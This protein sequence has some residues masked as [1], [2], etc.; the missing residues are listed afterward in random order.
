MKQAYLVYPGL[1]KT[2]LAKNNANIADI[3]TKIF[4]DASLAP[5][6]GTKDYPNYRGVVVLEINPDWPNNL[7]EYARR[8]LADGKIL[9]SVPKQDTYEMLN[10]L[11]ITDYA[12]IMPDT[13]RLEQLRQD[14]IKRGDNEE[15]IKRNLNDRYESVL[16]YAHDIKKEVIFVKPNEYLADVLQV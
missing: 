4:K 6:I 9:V 1:G 2:T 3:E 11:E 13:E 14:Y 8:K 12:F 15:Y 5:Y 10:A 7:Y 16:K